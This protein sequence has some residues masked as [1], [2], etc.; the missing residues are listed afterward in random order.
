MEAS[1]S[2]GWLIGIL[3]S[4]IAGLMAVGIGSMGWFFKRELKRQEDA[5]RDLYG[6]HED[7][8]AEHRQFDKALTRAADQIERLAETIKLMVE[9][10]IG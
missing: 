6:K 3:V 1:V 9:K 4:V 5:K 10:K 8:L 2:Q 7:N